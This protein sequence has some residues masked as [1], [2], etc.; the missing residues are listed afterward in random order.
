MELNL[1]TQAEVNQLKEVL[2]A[3]TKIVICAHRSPDGDAIGSSLAWKHY[4]NQLGK[5]NVKVCMPDATPDFLHWLPGNNSVIRYDRR[6]AEV[7]KAF[8]EA[9]LVCCLDF[10]QN[11][12]V[13]AM[14]GLLDNYKGARLLID[15]HLDPDTRNTM[16]I[17]H[18]EMSSTCEIVFR[19][20]HQLGGYD[21]M[22]KQTADCIYCGMMTDTGGFTYNSSEP[23]IFYIIGLLLQKGINKDEI[24]NRVFH[25][26]ST[27]ALRLRAHIILNKMKV[28]EELHASYY[29]VTKREMEK[30][31]FIKGDMEG[32]VNIPQQMKGLKLSI[33]LREDTEK[34][35][36]VLVSLRSGNGFHCQPMA[37]LFFNGGGHADASGGKLHCSIDEAEQVALKAI[38]HYK[39]ELQS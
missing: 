39:E 31:H 21:T 38:L 6:Q 20:I 13:D 1:L 35:N 18:P 4:L 36:T 37:T 16:T 34:P 17:S 30:F 22:T 14:Q 32:L 28:I 25:T 10:N 15:H 12:R 19:L 2:A 3:A 27:N 26:L 23:E 9:D 29:T 24:F 7:T 8:Q 5:T 11:H 33:S